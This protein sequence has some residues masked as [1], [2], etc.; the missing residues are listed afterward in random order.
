[1]TSGLEALTWADVEIAA[2]YPIPKNWSQLMP[3]ELTDDQKTALTAALPDAG[4]VEIL[5]DATDTGAQEFAVSIGSVFTGKGWNLVSTALPGGWF[6]TPTGLSFMAQ[7]D[8]PTS[9]TQ[10]AVSAALETSDIEFN[11]LDAM[12][13]E[14]V[15]VKLYVG[16]VG[17]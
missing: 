3:R 7:G 5:I 14:G 2:S 1:M 17:V 9:D 4:T 15:D 8:L 6:A 11:R 16:R 12:L 13:P 10:N